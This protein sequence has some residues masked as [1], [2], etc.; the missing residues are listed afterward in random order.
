M[1]F[2]KK[3]PHSCSY[4]TFGTALPDGQF[5]CSRQGIR[6]L[7]LPCWRFRYDPIKRIPPK[8]STLDTKKFSEEDFKL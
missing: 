1:L 7:D 4:C 5:L 6:P 2:R 8:N 3:Q